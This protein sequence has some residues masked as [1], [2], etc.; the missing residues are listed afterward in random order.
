MAFDLG[1]W[2]LLQTSALFGACMTRFCSAS[3]G[4]STSAS[5]F[6]PIE[7]VGNALVPEVGEFR[8]FGLG[9]LAGTGLS[10][11]VLYDRRTT[12]RRFSA[13]KSLRVLRCSIVVVARVVCRWRCEGVMR[14]VWMAD[15]RS[16]GRFRASRLDPIA[17][18]IPPSTSQV[19]TSSNSNMRIDLS[20]ICCSYATQ[21]SE[22]CLSTVKTRS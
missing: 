21:N 13:G 9:L 5:S 18:A 14:D 4:S 6:P 10:G 17:P 3:N 15:G 22:K 16:S 7:T 11:W 2:L 20:I 19:H 12:A 8:S 1:C